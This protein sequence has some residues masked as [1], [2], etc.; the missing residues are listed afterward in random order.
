MKRLDDASEPSEIPFPYRF[1][2]SYDRYVGK[3]IE[4]PRKFEAIA[5]SRNYGQIYL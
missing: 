5:T 4:V 1:V 2:D 3:N